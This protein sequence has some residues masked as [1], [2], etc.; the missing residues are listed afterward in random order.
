MAL[1]GKSLA[2]VYA[3]FATGNRTGE[4]KAQNT[5]YQYQVERGSCVNGPLAA[6]AFSMP[7][8]QKQQASSNY[9]TTHRSR[10]VLIN[11]QRQA[12]SSAVVVDEELV[13]LLASS[14]LRGSRMILP[15][16]C[17]IL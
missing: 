12:L 2:T 13:Y 4:Q 15:R 11:R 5:K 16:A 8:G 9:Y 17:S 3:T 14:I 10:A 7:Q 6:V 1:L